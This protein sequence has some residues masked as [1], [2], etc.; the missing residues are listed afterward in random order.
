LGGTR[1][2]RTIE[3]RGTSELLH[4]GGTTTPDCEAER[5]GGIIGE[6]RSSD[7]EQQR[8]RTNHTTLRS[9]PITRDRALH[10]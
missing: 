3:S 2:R 5:V 1:R 4:A 9:T 10:F 8:Y 6:W 7:I